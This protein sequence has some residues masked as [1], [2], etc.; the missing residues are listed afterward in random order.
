ML[1]KWGEPESTSGCEQEISVRRG[2]CWQAQRGEGVLAV[3][4]DDQTLDRPEGGAVIQAGARGEGDQLRPGHHRPGGRHPGGAIRQARQHRGAGAGVESP[5]LRRK[6]PAGFQENGAIRPDPQPELAGPVL[7]QN[8]R[9]QDLHIA[10]FDRD[11]IGHGL[12]GGG[13]H[14]LCHARGR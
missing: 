9:A 14:H 12:R 8:E 11:G 1:E 4:A 5:V 7:F 2:R 3:G 10:Q 13:D 6:P